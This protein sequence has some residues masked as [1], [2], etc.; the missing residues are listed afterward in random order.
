MF[1][2]KS[3]R[4]FLKKKKT[5]IFSSSAGWNMTRFLGPIDVFEARSYWQ[6]LVLMK[7]K[8][9]ASLETMATV[10]EIPMDAIGVAVL[11]EHF[12]I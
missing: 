5:S 7:V 9:T 2:L 10:K 11:S 6:G 3:S 12:L 8:A 4:S 1:G